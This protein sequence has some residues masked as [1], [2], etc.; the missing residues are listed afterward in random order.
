MEFQY[1]DMTFIYHP[2]TNKDGW[3]VEHKF[4]GHGFYPKEVAKIWGRPSKA[5]VFD[6]IKHY[7]ESH[8]ARLNILLTYKDTYP[9]NN[10]IFN[11]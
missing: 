2:K 9:E 1:L 11:N 8:S 3:H 6:I 7:V 5:K 4:S 10:S